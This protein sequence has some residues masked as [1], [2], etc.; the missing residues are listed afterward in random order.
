M[1][2]TK[3]DKI[4]SKID[5]IQEDITSIKVIAAAQHETLKDHTRR[6][7]ANEQAVEALAKVLQPVLTHV[8][9]MKLCGKILLALAGTEVFWYTLVKVFH[10]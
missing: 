4:D 1:Q 6:S 7:L 9:I 5:R 3:I 2:D 8:A 10:A